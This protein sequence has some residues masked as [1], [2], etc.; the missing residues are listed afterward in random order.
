MSL[1]PSQSV[2][3]IKSRNKALIEDV[4]KVYPEKTAKR[5]AKHLNVHEAGKP[6]CGVKSNIKSIPGVMTIRGCA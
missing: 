4:L 5:R 1:S 6:D 2:A 3:E